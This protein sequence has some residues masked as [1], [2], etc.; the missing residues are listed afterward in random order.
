LS[1]RK[2][3]TAIQ[4]FWQQATI[5]VPIAVFEERLITNALIDSD[6]TSGCQVVGFPDKDPRFYLGNRGPAEVDAE[7]SSPDW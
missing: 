7:F 6:I 4:Q 1:S 5:Y 3:Y 2:E